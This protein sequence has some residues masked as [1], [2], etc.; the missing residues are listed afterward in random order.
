MKASF[1]N[2]YLGATLICL[3]TWKVRFHKHAET[4]E[5]LDSRFRRRSG[6]ARH[7]HR[8]HK[9]PNPFSHIALLCK[10]SLMVFLVSIWVY[11]VAFSRGAPS[12]SS[13]PPHPPNLLRFLKKSRKY[14][15]SSVF[16]SSFYWMTTI[17]TSQETPLC[18]P[19]TASVSRT[20]NFGWL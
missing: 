9:S 3:D 10:L 4:F 14:Q 16:F 6:F 18:I 7:P 17:A 1:L 15:C 12:I 2:G 11:F 19:T 20:K 5:K 13:R 8:L